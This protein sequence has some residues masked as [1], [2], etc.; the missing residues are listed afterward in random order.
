[1]NGTS[2]KKQGGAAA[3]PR[4]G[5]SLQHPCLLQRSRKLNICVS[6]PLWHFIDCMLPKL[7]VLVILKIEAVFRRK[8]TQST[9]RPTGDGTAGLEHQCGDPSE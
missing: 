4:Q 9:A 2:G 8:H 6:A 5:D 1:M 3:G 7:T